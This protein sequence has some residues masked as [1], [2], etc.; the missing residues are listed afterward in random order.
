[1]TPSE[2]IGKKCKLDES[3]RKRKAKVAH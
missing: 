3:T 2:L 1:M